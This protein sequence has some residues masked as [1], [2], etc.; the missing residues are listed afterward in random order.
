MRRLVLVA[1]LLLPALLHPC[2]PAPALAKGGSPGLV[3]GGG[4]LSPYF[5][6]LPDTTPGGSGGG[7]TSLVPPLVVSDNR[8]DVP[9]TVPAPPD[10]GTLLARAYDLYGD[11][12]E[13]AR[14]TP[15]ARFVPGEGG[16]PAYLYWTGLSNALVPASERAEL[17]A[18]SWLEL[19]PD[20]AASLARA[21]ETALALKAGGG[22]GLE[23]DP[24]DALV[25]HGPSYRW[26][27]T[28]PVL[29]VGPWQRDGA[30]WAG[31]EAGWPR[32]AGQ[33][34]DRFVDAYVASLKA[35]RPAQP[36]QPPGML[37]G[38]LIRGSGFG[39]PLRVTRDGGGESWWIQVWPS[40]TYVQADAALVA[41]VREALLAAFD[42]LDGVDL[43]APTGLLAAIERERLAGVEEFY[44]G[45]RGLPPPPG[46]GSLPPGWRRVSGREA[47]ALREAY[48]ASLRLR[49]GAPF[50]M[51]EPFPAGAVHVYAADAA[52]VE[53]RGRLVPPQ[54]GQVAG[55]SAG[56]RFALR[57]VGGAF[58]AGAVAALL[59]ARR[60]RR[61]GAAGAAAP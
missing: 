31:G 21:V 25:R 26:L 24:V 49:F 39:L 32:L 43:T 10:A 56:G 57:V 30:P 19:P 35:W 9:A 37:E 53:I 55:G 51:D 44:V 7:W 41:V 3:L 18:G 34:I 2:P 11:A 36:D 60:A 52:L 40:I 17:P 5:Y 61:A 6:A 59:A 13:A 4:D 8:L 58:V 45:V 47:E 27:W 20:L 33:D 14:R 16:R 38:F 46:A 50:S 54:E 42:S 12:E 15:A 28:S 22:A 23:T 1:A 29:L 48:L